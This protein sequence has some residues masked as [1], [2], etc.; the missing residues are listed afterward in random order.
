MV[1]KINLNLKNCYGIGELEAELEFKHKCFAIYAPNGVMKTSLAKTMIDLSKE[2]DPE[3]V[4]FPNRKTV[5]KVTW[6]GDLIKAEEIFVV[7]PI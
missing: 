4:A 3:D 2:D 5:G 6:N 7:K 1:D